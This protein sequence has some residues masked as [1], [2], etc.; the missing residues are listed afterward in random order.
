M[1][2]FDALGSLSNIFLDIN[3]Y[4]AKQVV[5]EEIQE[6]KRE[7]TAEVSGPLHDQAYEA[8]NA[9]ALFESEDNQKCE[10]T[11]HQESDILKSE[12]EPKKKTVHRHL[13]LFHSIKERVLKSLKPR[14]S[15]ISNVYDDMTTTETQDKH[16]DSNQ[17]AQI[18]NAESPSGYSSNINYI[19]K[20][21]GVEPEE[22]DQ[23]SSWHR[24]GD[25]GIYS[26]RSSRTSSKY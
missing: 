4:L 22:K 20:S 10:E 15:P 12:D 9:C 14:R 8:T 23:R 5:Y 13:S 2:V 11:Q 24:Q 26:Y 21:N 17:N 25:S 3:N 7:Y 1:D 18:Q 6:K 16:N 19:S